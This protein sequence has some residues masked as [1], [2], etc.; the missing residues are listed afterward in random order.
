MNLQFDNDTDFAA[1]TQDLRARIN[2]REIRSLSRPNLRASA[3]MMLI[4]NKNGEAHVLLTKRTSHV[5][6]HKGEVSFPGGTCDPEDDGPRATAFRETFEEVGIPAD[7]I[8]YLGEFDHF[9]SIAGFHVSTFVGVIGYPYTATVNGDEIDA[10]FEAP[11]AIF[12]DGKYDK[13]QQVEFEGD[14]FNIYHYYYNGFE[15]WGLTAR[16]LTDFGLKI[17]CDC[18]DP[19]SLSCPEHAARSLTRLA[20]IT[21]ESVFFGKPVRPMLPPHNKI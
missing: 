13:K 7:Q 17:L 2:A 19:I 14:T 5:G 10:C 16:I 6:T 8:E 20:R 15:I 18:P 12:R 21:A 9:M 11:L 1:F 4:M 3:V